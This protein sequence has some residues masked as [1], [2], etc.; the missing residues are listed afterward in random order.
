MATERWVQTEHQVQTERRVQT[1][2]RVQMERRVQTERQVQ[3]E[4]RVQMERRVQTERQVQ[5]VRIL[6][7]KAMQDEDGELVC[8]VQVRSKERSKIDVTDRGPLLFG[9]ELGTSAVTQLDCWCSG[10]TWVVFICP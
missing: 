9:V 7:R 2:H 6:V 8:G 1:E 5:M 4:R 10:R 3:T